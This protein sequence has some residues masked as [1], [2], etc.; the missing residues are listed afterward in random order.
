M[1][2]DSRDYARRDSGGSWFGS[3]SSP[4]LF[5]TAVKT[6]IVINVAV[7]VAQLLLTRQAGPASIEEAITGVPMPR[8]SLLDAWFSLD[9]RSVLHG[10]IWRL[11]TYDFLHS[12]ASPWHIFW[13]MYILWAAGK[14]LEEEVL[15]R[16]EFFAF[17]LAAGV[18]SGLCYLSWC[19]VMRQMVPA[20]GASGAVSAVM[21]F[22]ALRYPHHV[23]RIMW[24]FPI[25]VI[26]IAVFNLIVD[27]HP[28]LLQL[29][30][31][32]YNDGVAHAAHLGGMAFGYGC[33]RYDWRVMPWLEG[34]NLHPIRS[35]QRWRARRR[36]RIVR[37]EPAPP[38]KADRSL[39]AEVDRVLAKVHESG[40][41]SL[42]E[43]EQAILIEASR[44]YKK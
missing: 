35:W 36:F 5:E 43:S 42:T 6:L 30:G 19:L 44:R 31:D 34:L 4:G 18:I 25:P 13:N 23:W 3:P 41:E 15:G 40:Q 37:D 10:Q 2:L 20:I 11:T 29:G 8:Q 24:V 27:L 16:K 38:R 26:W 14:H 9:P 12:R 33:Y 7:Y 39:E 28:V 17:Y 1:G 32:W 21:L 22:Y